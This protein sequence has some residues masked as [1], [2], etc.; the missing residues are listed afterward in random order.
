L[1]TP[2]AGAF[3]FEECAFQPTLRRPGVQAL[4]GINLSIN[5]VKRRFCRPSGAWGKNTDHPVDPGGL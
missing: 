5:P 3:A 2:V 1:P 4:D